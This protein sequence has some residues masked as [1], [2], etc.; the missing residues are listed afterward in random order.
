MPCVKQYAECLE[1]VSSL[2]LCANRA[3]LMVSAFL[4]SRKDPSLKIGEAANAGYWDFT[5][6][7]WKPLIQFLKDM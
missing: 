3:K 4:A 1:G 5:Q 7:P 2:T 6:E